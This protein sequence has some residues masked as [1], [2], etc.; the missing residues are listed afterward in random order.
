[1]GIPGDMLARVFD[2]F[3]QVDRSLEKAQGGL[4]IGLSI[5]KRLVEMH[6]GRIEAA[7]GGDRRGS[8]F[9]VWLPARNVADSPG[10][11]KGPHQPLR[12]ARHRILVADDNED[13]AATLSMIL[14][15]MGND[16]R[17][18]RDGQDAVRI[19][20]EFAPDVVLLDIGMPR[21]NGYDACR[22]IRR[23]PRCEG[24][25]LVAL[26]GWGQAQDREA[27]RRAGFDRHLV[28]PLE[29]RMLEELVAALPAGTR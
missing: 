1:V 7:S 26:T 21:M 5:A 19:A 15:L 14:E 20:G 6:A 13:S 18:A 24:A 10:T 17:T 3:T 16:V 8:A 12:Q 9:T 29:P 22:A 11:G 4:G 23:L 2:I 25:T 28:K 27:A